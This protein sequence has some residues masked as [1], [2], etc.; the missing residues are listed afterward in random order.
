MIILFNLFIYMRERKKKSEHHSGTYNARD[1]SQDLMFGD[2]PLLFM[3]ER[4][5]SPWFSP[6]PTMCQS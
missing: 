1:Q 3:R 5:Q 4:D 2:D 6:L